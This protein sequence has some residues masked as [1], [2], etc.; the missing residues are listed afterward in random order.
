MLKHTSEIFSLI[1]RQCS[2][3][4][5]RNK[6]HMARWTIWWGTLS[7]IENK[8]QQYHTQS[9]LDLTFFTHYDWSVTLTQEFS[10]VV[11]FTQTFLSFPDTLKIKTLMVLLSYKCC[12]TFIKCWVNTKYQVKNHNYCISVMVKFLC[13]VMCQ[14]SNRS[15]S[16]FYLS[17]SFS[18]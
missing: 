10:L 16:R 14:I 4:L 9:L 5:R 15:W 18:V 11:S 17:F 7:I 13:R 1:S 12:F 2:S 8:Y 6:N 3:V